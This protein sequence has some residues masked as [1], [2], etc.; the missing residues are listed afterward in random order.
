MILINYA[1]IG[2]WSDFT[3]VPP[4]EGCRIFRS[5][6]P[7]FRIVFVWRVMFCWHICRWTLWTQTSL[8]LWMRRQQHHWTILLYHDG[9]W[10]LWFFFSSLMR[11][12]WSTFPNKTILSHRNRNI[13]IV[14]LIKQLHVMEMFPVW[15]FSVDAQPTV[16]KHNNI[17]RELKCPLHNCMGLWSE[18]F[19]LSGC[20]NVLLY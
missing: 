20:F 13:R 2:E 7:P 14:C 16:Q 11:L 15:V 9:R 4:H 3:S 1:L 6:Y 8:I 19:V 10:C 18:C 5:L 12:V 17:C